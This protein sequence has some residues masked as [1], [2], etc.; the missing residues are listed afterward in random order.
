MKLCIYL[1]WA[2]CGFNL[3]SGVV[4]HKPFNIWMANTAL[5]A[6]V[7]YIQQKSIDTLKRI[8]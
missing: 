4:L 2:L 3:V 8:I 6:T 5:W 7:S 1:T